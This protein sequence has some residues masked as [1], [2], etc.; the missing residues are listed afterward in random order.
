MN[1]KDI[2]ID[3][4]SEPP[5]GEANGQN[6]AALDKSLRESKAS[7]IRVIQWDYFEIVR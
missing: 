4:R 7:A 1:G 2:V 6:H 5:L 3:K